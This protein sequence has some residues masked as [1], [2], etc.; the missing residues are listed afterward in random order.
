MKVSPVLA[1]LLLLAGAG[2]GQ[3]PVSRPSPATRAPAPLTIAG[4]AQTLWVIDPAR[5]RVDRTLPAG[6]PSPDRRLVYRLRAG[7]IDV[8]DTRTGQLAATH[9]APAWAGEVGTSAD[10]R[11][12]VL[13]GAGPG[14][15]FQV[16]DAAWAAPPVNAVVPGAFT[17]DAI[18]ADASRLYLL[19]WMGSA[20]YR[21]RMYDLRRGSLTAG[22]IVDKTAID[23]PVSGQ[24]LAGYTTGDG[25]MQLTLYQRG[26]RDRAFVHALPIGQD[27]PFAF[28]V[29]LPGPAEGW[30]FAPAPDGRRFYAV[31]PQV[32]S[33]LELDVTRPGVAPALRLW[34][35][36]PL[37]AGAA[38]SAV[39]APDGGTV[40]VAAGSWVTAI[41]V[42]TGAERTRMPVGRPLSSLA[43][44]PDGAALYAVA[45]SILLRLDPHRLV[46]TGELAPPVAS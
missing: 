26:S 31:N 25:A 18:S 3:Q 43:V 39:V 8:L 21:V 44:A 28:C 24:A 45:G 35:A 17:F 4:P 33:V 42:R 7:A 38:T 12:L 32:G 1:T 16:Q 19:E 41:D 9:Q 29:D 34:R 13:S 14:D 6:T 5:G 23:E 22:V 11:W 20:T 2:C 46:V 36:Q 27:V 37:P 10:G 40:Y 15:R 30:G